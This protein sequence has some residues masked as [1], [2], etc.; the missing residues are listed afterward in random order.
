MQAPRYMLIELTAC[1]QMF[2]RWQV[3]WL[4]VTG[5]ILTKERERRRK[6]KE[7]KVGELLKH[8]VQRRGHVR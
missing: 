6:M 5:D 2:L 3:V 7:M 8:C 4:W 1:M